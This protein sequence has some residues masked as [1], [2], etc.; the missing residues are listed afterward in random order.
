MAADC[1]S[2]DICSASNAFVLRGTRAI[3]TFNRLTER[4]FVDKT[5]STSMCAKYAKYETRLL[6]SGLS[7]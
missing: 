4:S 6:I 5:K 3:Q 2:F 7:T 1:H